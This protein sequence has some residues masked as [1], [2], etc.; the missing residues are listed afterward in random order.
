M[1]KKKA[2]ILTVFV[3]LGLL[4]HPL[5]ADPATSL[6]TKLEPNVIL[7]GSFFNGISISVS[8]QVSAESE[9][10]V[11]LKGRTEDLTLKKKGRVLGVLWMNLGEVTFQQVPKIYLLYTS[12]GLDEFAR[13]NRE[14]WE[15]L[16][17][18]LE[19]FKRKTEITPLL[20]EKD[21]LIQ[22]FLKLKQSQGLY[23]GCQGAVHFENIDGKWKSYE[24]AV[25]V[26]ARI[27]PGEYEVDVLELHAGTVVATTIEQLKVKEEGLPA[28]L[29][30]LA[31]K[32]GTLYGI[33]A[34]L[35]AI[36]AGLLMDFFFGQSKGAH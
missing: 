15:Q 13:S 34:V 4:W 11:I 26:P 20:E 29:A 21:S 17:I 8:G 25:R 27:A 1:V 31:F 9:V 10:L 7:I 32:H 18:G 23:A 33:L 3:L 24:A 14:Q 19:S 6:T 16:G 22:E 28:I 36:G 12:K 5:P 30:N 2:S 35:I